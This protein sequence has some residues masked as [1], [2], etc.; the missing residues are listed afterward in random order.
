MWIVVVF[1]IAIPA[2]LASLSFM[3]TRPDSLGLHDGRLAECPEAANCVCSQSDAEAHRI[4]ALRISEKHLESSREMFVDQL[5]SAVESLSGSTITERSEN[6]IH[7]ECK[8]MIFRFVDD[9]ELY[10]D[11]ENGNLHFRSASRIGY[12]DLGAN[13]RRVELIRQELLSAGLARNH[14]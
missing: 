14:Q 9:F 6:Y 1:A 10:V 4:G 13:R 8:S 3:A 7:A 5:A 12:S 11:W 2:V